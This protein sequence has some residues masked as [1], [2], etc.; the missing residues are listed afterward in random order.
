MFPIAPDAD[1][2][3]TL[4]LNLDK[5]RRKLVAGAAK[6]R[7][8][9]LFTVEFVL[10]DDRTLDGHAVVVPTRYIGGVIALH[11]FVFDDKIF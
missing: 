11:G 9:H 4:F 8:A 7:N 3:K 6:F 10:L 5:V 1:A 2:L